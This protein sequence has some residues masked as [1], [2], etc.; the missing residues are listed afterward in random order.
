[1]RA[2][3]LSAWLG[4]VPQQR[5]TGGK[6]K[7]G[8]ISKRVN[9]YLRKL[10]IVGAQSV[11]LNLDRSRH[12]RLGAWLAALEKRAHG[13]VA[14]VALANKIAWMAWAVLR[15]GGAYAPAPLPAAA[16]AAG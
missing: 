10:L 8:G 9:S 5:S 16:A 15:R 11:R 12:P 7:L 1:M 4:L 3:D 2:R 14:V 6:T 13:N